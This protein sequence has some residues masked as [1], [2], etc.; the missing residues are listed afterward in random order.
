MDTF[1]WVKC[2]KPIIFGYWLIAVGWYIKMGYDLESSRQYYAKYFLKMLSMVLSIYWL[3]NFHEQIFSDSNNTTKMYFT[4]CANTHQE[5]R[6]FVIDGIVQ[7]AKNW[8]SQERNMTSLWKILK[9]V[10]KGHIFRSYQFAAQITFKD[11]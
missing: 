1:K 5:V 6:T 11:L 2:S 9:I 3:I 8:I 10:S 7:I 4:S